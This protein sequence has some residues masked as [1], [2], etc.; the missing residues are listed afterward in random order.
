MKGFYFSP[1]MTF[2]HGLLNLHFLL[3]IM[4]PVASQLL[5]GIQTCSPVW[6]K[7]WYI[8]RFRAY[9]MTKSPPFPKKYAGTQGVESRGEVI[10]ILFLLSS[11]S[12]L[13]VVEMKGE[14]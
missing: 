3:L 14:A 4:D 10:H 8:T 2:Q 9:I 11:A 7:M 6:I 5:S 1:V 12:S 13:C